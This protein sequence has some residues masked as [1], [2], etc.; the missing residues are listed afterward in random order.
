MDV[1]L[2][3]SSGELSAE[4]TSYIYKCIRFES[5]P[6]NN[7]HFLKCELDPKYIFFDKPV[8][9][10][11]GYSRRKSKTKQI[12][13]FFLVLLDQQPFIISTKIPVNF[14]FH[15]CSEQLPV[16]NFS[17]WSW[18]F[19]NFSSLS[20]YKNPQKLRILRELCRHLNISIHD[21]SIDVINLR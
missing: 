8:V 15:S 21:S 12:F 7:K 2:S 13:P 11:S 17:R 1:S 5:T 20:C 18:R 3:Q 14:D 9:L 10:E 19:K 4:E 16:V 6:S